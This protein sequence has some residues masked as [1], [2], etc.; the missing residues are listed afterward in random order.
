[1]FEKKFKS[2]SLNREL[3]R[4]KKQ[5]ELC[6]KV[7]CVLQEMNKGRDDV[8]YPCF[9]KGDLYFMFYIFDVPVTLFIDNKLWIKISV[10]GASD[11][12]IKIND[13]GEIMYRLDKFCRIIGFVETMRKKLWPLIK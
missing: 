8:F 4:V 1:M 10:T 2:E 11:E 6:D 12:F 3:S 7:V 9:E 13:N 5:F